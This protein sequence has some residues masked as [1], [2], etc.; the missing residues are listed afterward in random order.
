MIVRESN[1]D[2]VRLREQLARAV[3]RVCPGWLHDRSED[4]IQAAMIRVMEVRRKSDGDREFTSAYLWKVAY[5][6][7]IDEIRRLR[8]RPET[9]LEEEESYDMFPGGSPNPERMLNSAEMGRGIREC[10]DRLILPR[11]RAVTLHLL[12]HSVPEAARILDWNPKR[13]ENLVYRGLD[14]LR[15]CLRSKGLAP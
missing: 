8:R 11:R 1:E 6:A 5:S 3:R 2:Y 4:I 7:L 13:T 12:G 10:L 9:P 15:D 14:N